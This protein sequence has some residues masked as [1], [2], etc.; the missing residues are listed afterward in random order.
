MARALAL[1]RTV[2]AVGEVPVAALLVKDQRLVSVGV[3]GVI[4]H[5]DPTDHAEIVALR[6]GAQRVGNYRLGG[7]T[8]YVTLEPCPMCAGALVHSRLQRLVFGA[9]DP[10]TGAAGSALDVFAVPS[11]NHRVQVTPGVLAADCGDFLRDFF[12]QKRLMAAER[13]RPAAPHCDCARSAPE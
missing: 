2:V 13:S 7:M 9:F 12:R 11:L 10:R 6:R 5:C 3:N 8:L 1:A 4:R